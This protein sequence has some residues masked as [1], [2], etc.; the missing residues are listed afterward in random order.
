MNSHGAMASSGVPH[1]AM[2]SSGVAW[3]SSAMASPRS[4]KRWNPTQ[5]QDQAI[6]MLTDYTCHDESYMTALG[7]HSKRLT[8]TLEGGCRSAPVTVG[9]QIEKGMMGKAEIQVTEGDRNLFPSGDGMAVLSHDFVQR[10]NFCGLVPGLNEPQRYEVLIYPADE[11]T[12]S[13]ELPP[14]S[15]P[16]WYPAT[17]KDQLE[18]GNSFAALVSMPDGLGGFREVLRSPV[19]VA[20]IREKCSQMR[21]VVPWRF[22][23][24]E[25]PT[26]DPLQAVLSTDKGEPITK[27]FAMPT[28]NGADPAGRST[29]TIRADQYRTSVH[30]DASAPAFAQFMSHEAFRGESQ[31]Q[32]S[33]KSWALRIGPFAEHLVLIEKSRQMG[34]LQLVVDG[35]RLV[36]SSA[37]HLGCEDGLWRCNF[38]FLGKN[39][40]NFVVFET[41]Q[42]GQALGTQAEVP[43]ESL[44]E[45]T[46]SVLVS[47]TFDLSTARLQVDGL[48]FEQLPPKVS[49]SDGRNQ[50][51]VALESLRQDYGIHVPY[52]VSEVHLHKDQDELIM[53]AA[54]SYPAPAPRSTQSVAQPDANTPKTSGPKGWFSGLQDIWHACY[55]NLRVPSGDHEFANAVSED[56]AIYADYTQAGGSTFESRRAAEREAMNYAAAHS[57][58]HGYPAHGTA[59]S[60]ANAASSSAPYGSYSPPRNAHSHVPDVAMSSNPYGSNLP[61]GNTHS[62]VPDVPTSSAPYCSHAPRG[63]THSHVPDVPTSSAPYGS[64]APRGNTHSHVP[65]VPTSSAPYGSHAPRGNTHSH[66]PDVVTSS[67]PYGSFALNMR[68]PSPVQNSA[69]ASNPYGSYAPYGDAHAHAAHGFKGPHDGNNR[70]YPMQGGA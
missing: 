6:F 45:H 51:M 12:D 67:D 14:P 58:S 1:G 56:G 28:P 35:R 21:L 23:K 61:R 25:I 42:Y 63:N 59:I 40:L 17:L 54:P 41:D 50:S 64:H 36:E 32:R 68:P 20:D 3:A 43:Q 26:Q 65:D 5:S 11:P 27:F 55:A 66:V 4:K 10:W 62:H 16:S 24:L 19:N 38:R 53:P 52:K 47:S 31:A 7:S 48:E 33:A 60:H 57:A 46:C 15:Q 39:I 30:I 34:V 37:D 69:T 8:W 49:S 9:L 18:G 29:V 70:S 44:V 2:A 13:D 22:V